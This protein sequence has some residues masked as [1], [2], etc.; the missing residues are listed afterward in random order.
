M[1]SLVGIL[2]WYGN[3]RGTVGHQFC[4][5]FLEPRWQSSVIE[6]TKLLDEVKV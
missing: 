2:N 3:P 1:E 6:E 5:A 4:E